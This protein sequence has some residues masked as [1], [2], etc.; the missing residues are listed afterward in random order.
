MIHTVEKHAD[1]RHAI[2]RSVIIASRRQFVAML[3]YLPHMA[4]VMAISAQEI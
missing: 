2:G 4:E 1:S 3:P